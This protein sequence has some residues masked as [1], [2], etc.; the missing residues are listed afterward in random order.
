[1]ATTFCTNHVR[2]LGTNLVIY[3]RHRRPETALRLRMHL[4]MLGMFIA[5]GVIS[6]LLCQYFG[7][8]AIWGA[9]ILLAFV[10]IRL[11][12]ADLFYERD[13]LEAKPHG[14]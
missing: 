12:R 14:H 2:Q 10:F 1:M 13:R 7:L 8:R 3:A 9:A 5:G 4:S 11:C 6:T